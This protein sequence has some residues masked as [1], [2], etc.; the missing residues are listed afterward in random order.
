ML[1]TIFKS[2]LLMSAVGAALAVVLLCLKPITKK[3]FSPKWQYYIWLTVLIVMIVPVRFSLPQRIPD[4]APIQ[5]VQDAKIDME[6]AV[7]E[8]QAFA[9]TEQLSE[10]R[11]VPKINLPQNIMWYLSIIW[12]S[13]VIF[14][15]LAKA[16]KYSLFSRTIRQNSYADNT[17]LSIPKRLCARRTQMLDAPLIIGLVKPVLYLP[18]VELTENDMNYILMHEL[19][20]YKRHDILY[21]WFTMLVLS[22]HWFNPLIYPVSKQIDMDCEISCDA[23]VADG[24]TQAEQNDYMNMILDMLIS[25][26]SKPRPLTT[27][28]ASSKKILKRRFTMI[29]NKKK[30]SKFVSA[31]STVIAVVML[32]TTVFAS[33]VLSDLNKGHMIINGREYSITPVFIENSLACHTDSYYVPLRETFEAL[34]YEVLY[35]VEKEK[36][37]I[38]KMPFPMYDRGDWYEFYD[39]ELGEWIKLSDK[40]Y[41]DWRR[42]MATNN[43]NYYIAGATEGLNAQMPII[44]MIKDGKT[45]YCQLGSRN[46]SVGYIFAAPVLIDGKAYIPIRAVAYIVGGDDNVKWNNEAHDTYYEGALTFD[47]ENLTIDIN[48]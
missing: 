38:G 8:N 10:T 40:E 36:Y 11:A 5:T 7:T 41:N 15:L 33:G 28:M 32:G 13:G 47:E 30:E 34:G 22:V 42:S 45:E 1:I 6:T 27:Q 14:V 20:H 2:V 21:K 39:E 19:T 4:T 46:M 9:G 16:V 29:R 43:V 44:E 48:T 25:S 35:D 23:A 3:L 17:I 31:L 12:L 18:D 24:L 37:S 26:K